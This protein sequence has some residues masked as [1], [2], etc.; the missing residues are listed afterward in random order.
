MKV[1]VPVLFFL[2][3][4]FVGVTWFRRSA[5][6]ATLADEKDDERYD[7]QHY[8]REQAIALAREQATRDLVVS[9]SLISYVGFFPAVDDFQRCEFRAE[10]QDRW[11]CSL[12]SI[13][14]R[15]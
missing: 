9:D 10:V 12:S 15:E 3:L 1:I 5:S 8:T 6:G 13:P 4:L 2:A 11:V 14:W 7:V